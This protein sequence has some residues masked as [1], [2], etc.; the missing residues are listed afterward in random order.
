MMSDDDLRSKVGD[1]LFS[2]LRCM[3][4][5]FQNNLVFIGNTSSGTPVNI[6]A[7]YWNSDLKIGIGSIIPHDAAGFGGGSKIIAPGILGIDSIEYIHTRIPYEFVFAETRKSIFKREIDEIARLSGLNYIFNI[8][9]NLKGKPQKIFFGDFEYAH[10]QGITYLKDL[11]RLK[12]TDLADVVIANSYPLDCD[13]YQSEK[14]LFPAIRYCKNNGF[15]LWLSSCPE[16]IGYHYLS[17]NNKKYYEG[18]LK[19]MEKIARNF[20]VYFYS[21]NLS[22]NE[23]EYLNPYVKFT[24]SIEA[25]LEEIELILKNNTKQRV[26][27]TSPFYI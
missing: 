17:L 12:I 2:E 18:Y 21:K 15:I 20:N 6:N 14:G 9:W 24:D 10:E 19:T 8:V 27:I 23:F 25:T 11:S 16:G 3:S 1:F 4:H 7:D 22:K 26:L 13:F 5:D